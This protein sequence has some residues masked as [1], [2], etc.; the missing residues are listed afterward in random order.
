MH[1]SLD[2]EPF[3]YFVLAFVVLLKERL[4]E[5]P[6]L[7]IDN[8][9]PIAVNHQPADRLVSRNGYIY[10]DFAGSDGRMASNTLQARQMY[11]FHGK[12]FVRD[13]RMT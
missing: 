5:A 1:I 8:P 10:F 3:V 12:R 2:Y 7:G 4:D 9:I 11:A 13:V 6:F